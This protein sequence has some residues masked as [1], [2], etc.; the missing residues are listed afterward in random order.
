MSCD[1][2]TSTS[3]PCQLIVNRLVLRGALFAASDP[4]GMHACDYS[5]ERFNLIAIVCD[6]SVKCSVIIECWKQ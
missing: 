4:V 5:L 6:M 1:A 3:L 2:L